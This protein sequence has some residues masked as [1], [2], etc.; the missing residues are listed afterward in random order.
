V[1]LLLLSLL[2][3]LVVGGGAADYVGCGCN[4]G[5]VIVVVVGAV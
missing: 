3:C 1:V 4:D 2:L 5:V